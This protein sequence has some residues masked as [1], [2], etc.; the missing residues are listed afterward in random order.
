MATRPKS[1]EA[2]TLEEYRVSF[3]NADNQPEIAAAMAEY[4]YDEATITVGKNLLTETR[5]VFDANQTEKDE[6]MASSNDLKEKRRKLERTY[7]KHRRLAKVVFLKD[8]V[9]AVRLAIT[10]EIP[11]DYI[12]WLETAKKLYTV[13]LADTGIQT[14]LSRLGITTD[15]LNAATVQI[16][17]LE[18][19]RALYLKEVGESQ[20]ATKT[21]DAA[22]AKMDSWMRDFRAV[23]RIAL[24]DKPQLLE[25]LGIFVR[26]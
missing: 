19:A 9:T 10:G 15:D 18:A 17:D 5:Q 7:S 6:A 13:A 16:S 21:K 12:S 20:Q 14:K 26:S 1:K 25:A 8:P 23:A 22:F 11:K 4:G 2:E 24:E 3:E